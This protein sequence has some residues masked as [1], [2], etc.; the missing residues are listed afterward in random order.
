MD[1]WVE[2]KEKYRRRIKFGIKMIQTRKMGRLLPTLWPKIR[3][4]ERRRGIFMPE[5]EEKR[6]AVSDKDP[7]P[8]TFAEWIFERCRRQK[9]GQPKFLKSRKRR[10]NVTLKVLFLLLPHAS[11]CWAISPSPLSSPAWF[12][13]WPVFPFIYANAWC[14]AAQGSTVKGAFEHGWQG[15]SLK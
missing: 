7:P 6:T 4:R 5:N 15:K 9:R 11:K 1:D 14:L 2:G 12:T 8:P 13:S 3:S 10:R